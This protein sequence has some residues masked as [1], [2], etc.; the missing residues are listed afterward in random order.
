M[1]FGE[2]VPH[3]GSLP[4]R[5]V[6]SQLWIPVSSMVAGAGPES[7]MGVPAVVVNGPYSAVVALQ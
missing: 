7:T 4:F 2:G 1:L 6:W 3:V 5:F